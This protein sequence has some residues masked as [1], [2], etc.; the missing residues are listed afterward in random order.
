M[1]AKNVT[2]CIFLATLASMLMTVFSLPIHASENAEIL[3]TPANF[4]G[5]HLVPTSDITISVLVANVSNLRLV[6]LNISYEPLILS[7]RSHS[8]EAL[9]YGPQPT[10]VTSD[11]KGFFWLNVTYH[12]AI[13]TSSPMALVNVTFSILTIGETA[14]NLHSTQL[15]DTTGQ[16]I[17]HSTAGSYFNNF[18]LYDIN[19]DGKIDI[20][21]LGIMAKAFGSYPGHPRWNANADVNNDGYVNLTD[22]TIVASHFGKY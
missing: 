2:H 9:S 8:L 18:S 6:T 13:T 17:P 11:T 3:I 12:A 19:Q 5:S 15:L 21:D 7:F 10:V 4:E 20:L 22:I 1:N 16:P 14:L